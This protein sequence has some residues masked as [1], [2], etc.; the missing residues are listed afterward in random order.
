M[1][2]PADGRA[3]RQEEKDGSVEGYAV[4]N[5]GLGRIKQFWKSV[6]NVPRTNLRVAVLGGPTEVT[7]YVTQ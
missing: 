7:P 6:P 2:K 4:E 3:V 5:A 1:Q